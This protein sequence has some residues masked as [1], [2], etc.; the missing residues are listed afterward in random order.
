MLL[1]SVKAVTDGLVDRAAMIE[2]SSDD[3]RR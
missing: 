3:S 1:V 2:L